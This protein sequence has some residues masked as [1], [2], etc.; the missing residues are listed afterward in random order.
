[1]EELEI[2]EQFGRGDVQLMAVDRVVDA[3]ARAEVRYA[4]ADGDARA[5][6]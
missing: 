6:E 1:M 3:V 5:C 4:A 2:E